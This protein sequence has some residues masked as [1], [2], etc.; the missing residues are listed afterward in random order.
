MQIIDLSLPIDDTLKETHAASIDRITHAQGVEHLNWVIMSKQS[1][2][3]Q[4]FK[5]GE[6]IIAP[7]DVPDAELLSLEIVHSSVHMGTHV[8]APFHY[9][10]NSEGKPSKYIDDLPLEWCYNDGVVLDFTDKKHPEIISKQDII[11]ALKKI[12]YTLKPFDIVLFNTGADKLVGTPEYITKYVGVEPE[13]IEYLL[14]QGIKMMGIDALGLDRP[15]F[16][17]FQEFLKTKNKSLLWPSHFLGRKREYSHMERLA[18][19][20]KIPKPFGFKISC[21]PVKVR[22]AGAGWARVVAILD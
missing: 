5:K 16:E 8:D 22:N 6:R 9:G 2:G 10:S 3:E 1:D 14:D 18:N 11:N 12:N 20:S 15:C 7:D 19:L 13:A 17:M 4:R 21:L